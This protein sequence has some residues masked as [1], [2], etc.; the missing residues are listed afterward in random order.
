MADFL[1]P[2][3]GIGIASV[4]Y[5]IWRRV[6]FVWVVTGELCG[7]EAFEHDCSLVANDYPDTC[8]WSVA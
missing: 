1:L 4:R 7:H 3:G 6:R 8:T 2:C 5:W